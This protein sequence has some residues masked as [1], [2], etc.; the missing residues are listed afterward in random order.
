VRKAI[1][2]SALCG[3]FGFVFPE[4][5]PQTPLRWVRF[6]KRTHRFSAHIFFATNVFTGTSIK[7]SVKKRWVRLVEWHISF[8]SFSTAFA[9]AKPFL[10]L[11]DFLVKKALSSKKYVPTITIFS[12]HV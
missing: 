2:T 9:K 1:D 12:H 6:P 10:G 7:K 5:A 8:T 11:P 3:S 4:T